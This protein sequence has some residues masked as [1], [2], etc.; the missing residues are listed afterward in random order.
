MLTAVIRCGGKRGFDFVLRRA[1]RFLI[2][3]GKQ[4]VGLDH[5]PG[6]RGDGIA[7]QPEQNRFGTLRRNRGVGNARRDEKR[8]QSSENQQVKIAAPR[9]QNRTEKCHEKRKPAKERCK[10]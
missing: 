5:R 8:N 3:E 10:L 7:L 1:F 4:R 2:G 9:A 6:G